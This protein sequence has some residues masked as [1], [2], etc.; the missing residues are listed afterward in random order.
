M[1]TF[2]QA[3]F[4]AWLV[5]RLH[6]LFERPRLARDAHRLRRALV[7]ILSSTGL[8]GYQHLADTLRLCQAIIT[9]VNEEIPP[10]LANH[11]TCLKHNPEWLHVPANLAVC[12]GSLMDCAESDAPP[13]PEILALIHITYAWGEEGKDKW[14]LTIRATSHALQ[15]ILRMHQLRLLASQVRHAQDSEED[16]ISDFD[17]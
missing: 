10:T 7:E 13:A 11:E 3:P 9:I 8:T 6:S 17:D 2:L 5:R 4:S 16:P 14:C 1:D 15:D 12:C